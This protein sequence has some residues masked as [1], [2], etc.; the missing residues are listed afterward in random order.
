MTYFC[1][2][3]FRFYLLGRKFSVSTTWCRPRSSS[4]RED[5]SFPPVLGAAFP[6]R[7]SVAPDDRSSECPLLRGYSPLPCRALLC[8]P[9][10]SRVRLAWPGSPVRHA[11]R[12]GGVAVGHCGRA[13]PNPK[14]CP[15]NDSSY[16]LCVYSILVLGFLSARLKKQKVSRCTIIIKQSLL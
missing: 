14:M 9:H 15:C 10:R 2:V 12:R 6:A 13:G 5:R 7:G 1:K 8:G 11:G 16:R 3:R 4:G